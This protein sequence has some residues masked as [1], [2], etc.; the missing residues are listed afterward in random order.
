MYRFSYDARSGLLSCR[1]EGFWT[2]D[3]AT[4]YWR[5]L[6]NHVDRC[7]QDFGRLIYLIDA[8]T[9][10]PQSQAVQNY[11]EQHSGLLTASDDDR[12]AI[13]VESSLVKLQAKRVMP[14]AQAGVFLSRT[15]ADSWIRT[16]LT[17]R[18]AW[19][20]PATASPQ[21]RSGGGLL[22]PVNATAS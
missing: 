1:V 17:S 10:R 13:V 22:W 21:A 4:G 15:A 14:S 12:V 7:R 5:D 2:L 9:Y 18:G 11:S 20:S 16:F 19:R 3:V 6:K 8:A